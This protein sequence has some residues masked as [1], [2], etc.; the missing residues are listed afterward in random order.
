MSEGQLARTG[1]GIGTVAVFGMT[2]DGLWVLAAAAA[3]VLTGVVLLR[4]TW[5]RG[6]PAGE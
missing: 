6:R 2:V 1:L 3:L 4:C 5:R